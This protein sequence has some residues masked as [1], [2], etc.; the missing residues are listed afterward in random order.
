ML[1]AGCDFYQQPGPRAHPAP[2][3]D[4]K[5][6]TLEEG[7]EIVRA[8]SDPARVNGHKA[9]RVTSNP[10][11]RDARTRH[12]DLKARKLELETGQLEGRLIDREAVTA[13]GMHIITT[14]RTA[15]LSLGHRIADKVANKSD[16]KEIAR[17]VENEIRDVL[18]VLGDP[19]KFFAALEIDALS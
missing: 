6:I 10:D 12:E 15:L 4:P 9:T 5:I 8:I 2:A 3:R 7:A 11:L 18:G 1:A 13:T 17:I 16:T 19:D 14:A